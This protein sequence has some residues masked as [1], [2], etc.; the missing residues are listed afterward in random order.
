MF[1]TGCH[2]STANTAPTADVFGGPSV[3]NVEGDQC[4]YDDD[5]E[6]IVIICTTNAV[7]YI[8]CTLLLLLPM[9]W[10]QVTPWHHS[11]PFKVILQRLL[12]SQSCLL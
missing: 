2:P 11:K 9:C 12:K 4:N 3:F 5:D 8:S 6:T 7:A 1:V 10:L